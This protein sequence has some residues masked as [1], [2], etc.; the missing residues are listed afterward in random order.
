MSCFQVSPNWS[1]A[2]FYF[3]SFLLL[4]CTR[5]KPTHKLNQNN[6]I[7]VSPARTIASNTAARNA[8]FF[9][10]FSFFL[11]LF[12]LNFLWFLSIFQYFQIQHKLIKR[13]AHA[14]DA[15]ITLAISARMTIV[16]VGG[17]PRQRVNFRLID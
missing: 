3:I 8:N 16:D 1:Q 10:Q 4:N 12:L 6:H 5:M 17:R 15:E 13:I 14:F 2:Q 11:A 7:C 9:F